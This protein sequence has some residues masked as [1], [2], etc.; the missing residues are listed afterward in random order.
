MTHRHGLGSTSAEVGVLTVSDTRTLET[1][2]SGS[3]CG[4]LLE[5]GGHR[6]RYRDL[7]RDEPDEVRR[8]LDTWLDDPACD[9]VIVTGGTGIAPRDR[10]YD[11]VAS[12]LDQRL[13]GFG[14]LF[15][16]ISY[17]EIGSSAML[18][19]AVGGIARGR[20]VF[21]LPGSPDAVRLAMERLIVP[22]IGHLLG[23]LS[24]GR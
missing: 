4:R 11:V 23:L 3:L 9:G 10:T 12:R 16:S 2:R 17:G 1:D 7:V 14:E 24:R 20:F 8:R 5:N 18:S 19:R 21:S 15:R 22:E 13:D 6:V